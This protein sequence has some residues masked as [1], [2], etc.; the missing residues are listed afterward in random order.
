MEDEMELEKMKRIKLKEWPEIHELKEVKSIQRI[1]NSL[2][3][4]RM[5]ILTG[6]KIP[7]RYLGIK[8]TRG[9]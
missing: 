9:K 6:F 1:L 8:R 4:A 3:G 2:R 7:K 5:E